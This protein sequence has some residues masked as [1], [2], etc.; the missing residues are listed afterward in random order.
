M[1]DEKII[2]KGWPFIRKIFDLAKEEENL[3][4]KDGFLDFEYNKYF[5]LCF[6]YIGL[7]FLT[8]SLRRIRKEHADE[9]LTDMFIE[10]K[11]MILKLESE[12]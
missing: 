4:E 9:E 2:K 3:R 7:F 8:N 10:I 5:Y 6:R 12:Q 1:S 11:Q